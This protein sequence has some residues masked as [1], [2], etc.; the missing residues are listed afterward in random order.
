MWTVDRKRRSGA[1]DRQQA[2]PTPPPAVAEG[3]LAPTPEPQAAPEPVFDQSAPL[4]PVD[5]YG[6]EHAAWRR[7]LGAIGGRSSLLFFDDSP[8]NRIE[9]STTHPGG[10]PQFITGQKIL[11]STLIRDDLALRNARLAA[12][13]IT[14]KAIEMRTVRGLETVHLGIGIA[15]WSFEGEEFCAPVLLRPLAIR[16]Y[17]RDFELKLKRRPYFNPALSRILFEQFGVRVDADVF[18]ALSQESGVFKPQPVIDR[19]RGLCAGVQGFVVQPRLVASSFLDVAHRMVEDARDLDVPLL[20]AACGSEQVQAQLGRD[21]RVAEVTPPNQRPPETD[22]NLHDSDLEQ[23]EVIAQIEAGNSL[24]VHTLPG[25][26]G[27]QTVVNAIGALVA[28]QRR[29]LVVSARRATLDGIS[30]RLGRVGLPGLAATPRLLRR[31]VVEAIQRCENVQPAAMRDV[32]DALAR[33]RG[34]LL[35]YDE[36]LN[37]EDERYGVSPIEAVRALTRLAL[38]EEPPATT[39]RLDDTALRT[40]ALDRT[41]VAAGLTEAAGLGQ[42]QYG[43]E[44]SPWYG[45][46]FGTTEEA[47]SAFARAV[48]LAE[49][50]LPRLITLANEV[51]TQTSMRPYETINE[52]GIYLRLLMGIRDTLDRFTPEVYDR[53]LGEVI[54]AHAPRGGEEMTGPNRRR[55]R[56]LAKEYVRPGVTVT[57]MY[58]RLTQIQQQRVLWQRYTAVVGARP[59]IPVGISDVIVAFQAVYQDLEELDRVLGVTAESE[60][61]TQIALPQLARRITGLAEESEVLQNIQERTALIEELRNAHLEPLLEDL[62]ARHVPSVQVSVELEQ[63]WW[64]SVLERMLQTNKALLSANTTVLDR[65]EA[66]FRLVDDAHSG[67]NGN[68]MSARIAD[69]WRVAILDHAEEARVLR[70]ALRSNRADVE[71]LVA[72]APKLMGVLAPVWLVSPYEVHQL[73]DDLRFD[74]VLLVDAGATTFVENVGAIRRA[75][76]VVA[77][78]DP[79][80]QTPA[81]FEIGVT[82]PPPAGQE[83]EPVDVEELHQRSALAVLGELL[84][85]FVLTRSYRAG[86]EDLTELVNGRFYAGAIESLPWAGSFLGHHSITHEYVPGGQGLPDQQ[87]GAV[88]ST[89]AEVERVVQLV[90]EHA[91]ERPRESLMVITASEKHAVRV[92]QSVL[93]AFAKYPEHGEFLLG[94]RAEPFTVLTLEQ[95][96]AHSRDRVVFSI[97]YGRTPHGRVLSNFG[98]LGRPGGERLLAVAMTRAR[99]AMTIV[100]CFRPSDLDANRVRHGVV[101]LA[102]LLGHEHAAADA[103]ALPAEDD[104]MLA[105]LAERL[106]ARGVTV[107]LDY[108]GRIPLA[109]A[110]EGRAVAVETDFRGG[111]QSLRETLRL[112]P[113]VLRRL[114]W[115]FHRVHSFDLF[116]DPDAVADRVARVLGVDSARPAGDADEGQPGAG[117]RSAG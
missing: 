65:L 95:A 56:K 48:S 66:D 70:D 80:T 117:A 8:R 77:F 41:G 107:A 27:T 43:P 91:S 50:E 73:P 81:P 21:F 94:E 17:G 78:G 38:L 89:D 22:R 100:T 15:K 2:A 108:R 102:E 75:G 32:D 68:V 51:V 97:G 116:S 4:T 84:P 85:G 42:F 72:S 112:R 36:A 61:L 82:T 44:D 19:L 6:E 52:L 57:D 87:S 7:E 86:G 103:P 90:L 12:G 101:E 45:V 11:L 79:V 60:R 1:N 20:Q 14:D 74:T 96:T 55:L 115:H 9:L 83:P 92:Y 64:Q 88:E 54:A 114:G 76:Q 23:D 28:R 37:A 10:L 99:R 26:G 58:E 71:Q 111:S 105:D 98:A 34:V 25:T 106:R 110:W 53:S 31:N 35:D 3:T 30:H 39:A 104:P 59:S 40:L 5:H 13:R 69:E 29:V 49:T 46:T 18:V 62:S 93:A 16:R 113:A 33:L 67:A 24:V 63:A 47:R 109:A